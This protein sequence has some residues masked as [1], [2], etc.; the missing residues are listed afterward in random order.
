MP[1]VKKFITP[2]T[3]DL[4]PPSDEQTRAIASAEGISLTPEHW[5][6]IRY[7]RS[8]H[9]QHDE[10][11]HLKA[12]VDGLESKFGARGGRRFLYRLFPGGP[13]SQGCRIAG[14]PVPEGSSDPSFGSSY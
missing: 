14:V 2:S 8:F 1:D 12:L 5:T 10:D 6:V 11:Y 4:E 3:S 9:R 13:I 7:L